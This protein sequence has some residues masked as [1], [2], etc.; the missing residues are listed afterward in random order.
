M[1][2]RQ[3]GDPTDRNTIYAEQW[4]AGMLPSGEAQLMLPSA[5]FGWPESELGG[6]PPDIQW[7]GAAND[8]AGLRAFVAAQAARGR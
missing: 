4:Y 2:A 5:W 7:R 8:E 3:I 1:G 6:G